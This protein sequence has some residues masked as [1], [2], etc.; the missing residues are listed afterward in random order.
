MLKITTQTD[1]GTTA[2]KLDGK[3]T[4]P[5]AEELDRYWRDVPGSH[6]KRMLV[7][8]TGVTFIGSEGKAIL[9]RM[10]RQGARFHA[11]GC[12]NI[13]VL[14]EITGVDRE[15]SRSRKAGE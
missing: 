14:E 4:N 15:E 7:D 5:W 2:L 8:L 6:R 13:S 11:A 12:L 3:L 9:A 1:A 10:W